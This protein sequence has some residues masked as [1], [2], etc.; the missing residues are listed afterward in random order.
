MQLNGHMKLVANHGGVALAMCKQKG[1]T[2]AK[3]LQRV[4]T[5]NHIMN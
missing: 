1:E 4:Q 3:R 5:T 2:P